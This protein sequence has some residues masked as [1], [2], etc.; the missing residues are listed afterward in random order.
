MKI[1]CVGG[2]VRDRLLGRAV[3]DRDYVVVGA[4][5]EAMRA[6]G[7]KP[8]GRDF[9]VFLHPETHEEYALARTERKHGRGYHG[10]VFHAAPEVTLEEDLARRDLTINA[11]AEDG[12]GTVIDPYGGRADLEA[13]VLRH[14]SPA[15]AE[16][17]VR[18]L[19]VARFAA[20]FGDFSIAADTLALMRELVVSGEME[21]V[22]PERAWRE[23]ARGLMEA[24]P[25][26]LIETLR[27]CGAL[28][29]LMPE[30]DA[31]FGVPERRDYHPEGNGGRHVLLTLKAAARCCPTLAARFSALT[32]DLGKAET[33]EEILPRRYGHEAR[34]D[35][36]LLALCERLK[37]PN[38][39]R[40]LARLAVR[41]H[42][43]IHA[44]GE[45]RDGA[46]RAS[47]IVKTLEACDLR[48]RPGLFAELLTVCEADFRGRAGR[49]NPPWQPGIFW[50]RMAAAYLS[51]P[52][53]AL[54][55]EVQRKGKDR[56]KIPEYLRAARIRA[57]RSALAAPPEAEE[58]QSFPR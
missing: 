5:P 29:R 32:H 52:E 11:M 17:P 7:F 3:A 25:E 24:Y 39:C 38:E 53:R 50:R 4:T 46:P 58:P 8:V 1:Y 10:F 30:V 40:D 15:F 43:K 26:R 34:G 14:V 35:M 33:P 42:G 48:R 49:E 55:A 13:R 2:A 27:E 37:V 23:I 57:V 36:P 31:L 6:R 19:R 51:V 54:V 45:A 16:D 22:T 41:L 47:T 20:R 56:K 18:L 44:L 9:P 21:C 12:E 28:A